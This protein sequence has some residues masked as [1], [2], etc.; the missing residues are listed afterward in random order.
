[1]APGQRAELE[2]LLHWMD[3]DAKVD[4]AEGAARA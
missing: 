2:T 1:M 4:A 3:V